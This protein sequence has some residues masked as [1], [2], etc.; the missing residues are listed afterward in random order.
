ME[1]DASIVVDNSITLNSRQRYIPTKLGSYASA[2]TAIHFDNQNNGDKIPNSA[3][4]QGNKPH[5]LNTIEET[6]NEIP[7]G[8]RGGIRNTNNI[9]G[10]REIN[11]YSDNTAKGKPLLLA[12]IKGGN[13]EQGKTVRISPSFHNAVLFQWIKDGIS[14]D[15]CTGPVLEISN[16]NLYHSGAYALIASNQ[17]GIEITPPINIRIM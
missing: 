2:S 3:P 9:N 8:N 15:T 1:T 11:R 13:F 5:R 16:A 6:T 4:I 10:W 12:Q 17:F 7:L 14:L